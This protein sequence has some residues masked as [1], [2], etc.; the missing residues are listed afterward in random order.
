VIRKV[1][2]V[3]NLFRFGDSNQSVS[4]EA[5]EYDARRTRR[6]FFVRIVFHESHQLVESVH[7][8]R[9]QGPVG[10][11]QWSVGIESLKKIGQLMELLW[12]R[13]C[14]PIIRCI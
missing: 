14:S 2:A 10:N 1:A 6:Q 4:V 7:F 5:D 13:D 8:G 9:T 11:F 3:S 12:V